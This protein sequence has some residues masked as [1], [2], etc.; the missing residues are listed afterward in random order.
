LGLH[1]LEALRQGGLDQRID[2]AFEIGGVELL[3][4][5][6]AVVALEEIAIGLDDAQRRAGRLIGLLVGAFGA[7]GVAEIVGDQRFV[8]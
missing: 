8:E 7:D 4:L 5:G 6:R 2:V 1:A 3:G